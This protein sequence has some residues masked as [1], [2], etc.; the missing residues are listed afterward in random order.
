MNPTCI[1]REQTGAMA[2]LTLNRPD[3]HNAFDEPLI[4]ELT[5]AYTEL[6]QDATVRVIILRGAGKSFCAGADLN[7]M[8]RMADYT[9]EENLED[10]RR[11]EALFAAI[12]GCPQVTIA[13]IQGAAMGGGAGLAAV[14]DIAIAAPEAVFA[15]SEAR[16][17]IAP[18]VIAPYVLQKMSVGA[19]RVLFVTAERFSAHEALHLGLVQQVVPVEELDAAVQKKVEAVLQTSPRAIVAI[20]QLLQNI[21][22]KTPQDSASFTTECIAAL[23]VSLEGQEG[24]RAFLDK[25]KPDFVSS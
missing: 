1:L 8:R 15:F 6:S 25:R 18:A 12:A 5:Q 14:C 24:L 22:G 10:A 17:G 9:Q 4:A 3:V 19:A 21:A 16:L 23:R 11:L 2:T 20:K 13:R 7:W